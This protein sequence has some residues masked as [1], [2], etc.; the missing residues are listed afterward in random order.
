MKG[1]KKMKPIDHVYSVSLAGSD[2]NEL[3][4]LLEQDTRNLKTLLYNPYLEAVS[5]LIENKIEQNIKLQ[6]KLNKH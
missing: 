6:D 5:D 2:I 3:L 4:E 1:I